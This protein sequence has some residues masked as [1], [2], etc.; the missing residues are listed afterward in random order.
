[1]EIEIR[2][3]EHHKL[4][5]I[6]I[7]E[8]EHRERDHK[9]RPHHAVSCRFAGAY[10]V[11]QQGKVI[12][13]IQVIPP[14]T[15]FTAPPI[16]LDASGTAIVGPVGSVTSD[17]AG[18][19]PTLSADGQA[20]NFTSQALAGELMLIWHD[21]AGKVPDASTTFQIQAVV[22]PPPPPGPD[23]AVSVS[24]GPATPGTTP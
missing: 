21:P 2:I 17:N 14:S 5:E 24:F 3:N 8:R 19:N 6:E 22:V 11:N 4:L 20:V 16:F 1:M 18:V 10:Y 23:D 13:S 15:A 7:N 9:H 12:M